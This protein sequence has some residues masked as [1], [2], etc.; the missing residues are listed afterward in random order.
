MGPGAS[1]PTETLSGGSTRKS[2]LM[3][4]GAA[5]AVAVVAGAAFGAV[6]FLDDDSDAAGSIEV[7]AAMPANTLAMA[8]VSLEPD[9]VV[10]AIEMLDKFP[11]FATNV[12]VDADGD[13]VGQ[14]LSTVL[15]E[16]DTCGLTY[17]SDFKPWL[18]SSAGMGIMPEADGTVDLE[19]DPRVFAVV[20]TLD[21]DKAE[22][23]FT[24][25]SS[26]GT[27]AEPGAGVWAFVDDSAVLAENQETLDMVTSGIAGGSLADSE[28][29]RAVMDTAGEAGFASMYLSKS[30]GTVFGDLLA[31]GALATAPEGMVTPD[32]FVG[33]FGGDIDPGLESADPLDTLCPGAELSQP[34]LDS[35]TGS[36]E[37]FPGVGA[38]ARFNDG[39]LE[40]EG[41]SPPSVLESVVGGT[42]AGQTV[43]TLPADTAAAIGFSLPPGWTQS[44]ID[45]FAQVCGP[46][47][48]SEGLL[49]ELS[50][51][52]GLSLPDDLETLLGDSTVLSLGSGLNFED[53]AYSADPLA[54]VP[55]GIKIHGDTA[56]IQSVI[57]TVLALVPPEAS[58][59]LQTATDGDY[60]V[61]APN[62]DYRS[63]LASDGG[64]GEV[65]EFTDVVRNPDDASF[66]IFL[67]ANALDSVLEESMQSM[68]GTLDSAEVD[69]IVANYAPLK[70]I[71]I[72]G[73]TDDSGSHSLFR[74][75][76][77]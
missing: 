50:A 68:G 1:A 54:E 26:C 76:T 41:G 70:A 40:I 25:F 38:I 71:G 61:L 47:F 57:D 63:A 45:Q 24:K 5:V 2:V 75:S 42:G 48:D 4:G 6:K 66:V 32:D 52:I 69:Q 36:L 65:E 60:L 15:S 55:F 16:E 3:V 27:D 46:D 43:S 33:E 51:Q 19:S 67:N 44:V 77:D 20:E 30:F 21:A 49:D 31:S 35:M 22:A 39:G 34:D 37:A 23:A 59:Y 58:G 28:D 8:A 18:G 56:G 62:E 53:M 74:L 14:I 72:S 11:V 64:L 9:Q 17:E 7:A 10:E 29:F 12:D 13:V 73:W